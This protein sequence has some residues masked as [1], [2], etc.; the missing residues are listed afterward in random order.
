L[1]LFL[2]S[3]IF[4]P[5][6]VGAFLWYC[7]LFVSIVLLQ[8]DSQSPSLCSN[9][10]FSYLI[11]FLN[12]FDFFPFIS[13]IGCTK[14]LS[15]FVWGFFACFCCSVSSLLFSFFLSLFHPAL[16]CHSFYSLIFTF[17][18]FHSF[19]IYSYLSVSVF[20]LSLYLF[21]LVALLAPFCLFFFCIYFTLFIVV[22]NVMVNYH[23]QCGLCSVRRPYMNLLNFIVYFHNIA[24][25]IFAEDL[26]FQCILSIN[27]AFVYCRKFYD[28]P[29]F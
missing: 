20:I 9:D 3:V 12:S 5:T 19:F 16:L 2:F 27:H 24:K 15:L 6:I 1:L 4:G 25:Y 28:L 10:S 22:E 29:I 7:W 8:F 17:F 14:W 26:W 21:I 11:F 18:L 23:M 13:F